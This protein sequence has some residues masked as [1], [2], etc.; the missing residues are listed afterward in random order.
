MKFSGIKLKEAS[1]P[2][3][4]L[5]FNSPVALVFTPVANLSLYG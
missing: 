1:K 4:S 3:L 5:N 2:V